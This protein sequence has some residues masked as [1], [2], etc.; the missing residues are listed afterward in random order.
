M[1]MPKSFAASFLF[2]IWRFISSG[3]SVAQ[4][5]TIYA[6]NT[7]P[8]PIW[9]ATA[10]NE[11]QPVIA[12]GSFYLPPGQTKTFQAPGTWSGRIWARTGC[13]FTS[14]LK[15]A[16]KSGDYDG[17]LHYNG[18][19]GLPPT[20]LVEM[21]IQVDKTKL[22][23]YDVSLVDGYCVCQFSTTLPIKHSTGEHWQNRLSP[24][25]LSQKEEIPAVVRPSGGTPTIKSVIKYL[26]KITNSASL[27]RQSIK[28]IL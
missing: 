17:Q 4:A 10:P 28:D 13:N 16:C 26:S 11:G 7:C 22:I 1:K 20:T 2:L 24:N 14:N 5:Y 21:S 9:P 25:D 15:L 6:T 3:D 8:F 19:I 27:T 23:F 18:K 12:D